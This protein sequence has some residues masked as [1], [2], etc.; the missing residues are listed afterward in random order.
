MG[1]CA[2]AA[3]VPA[4][5]IGLACFS[6]WRANDGLEESDGGAEVIAFL[7]DDLA[8]SSRDEL[9]TVL[10][11]L[12]GVAGVRLLGSDE[13]LVR[14][15]SALGDHAAVLDGVE[16]G[17]LPATL[18]VS[19]QPGH[20]GTARADDIADRLRRMDGITDV[21]VLRTA[22]S[23]RLARAGLVDRR[24][25]RVGIAVGSL[26]AILALGLAGAAMRRRRADAHL[27]A[28]LGFSIVAVGLPGAISGASYA[29]AGTLLGSVLACAAAYLGWSS[30]GSIV[31]PVFARWQSSSFPGVL[32]GVVGAFALAVLLGAALGWWGA[33]PSVQEIDD[34]ASSD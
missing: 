2:F 16:D 1:I 30:L 12:P 31:V 6:A 29:L 26:T 14:M 17:F 34:L 13:T 24:L 25:E 8:N 3:V 28:G 18:E 5:V 21:D 27:M 7:R 33:R 4:T 32:G 10:R 9:S 19:L 20:Q 22:L 15:R 23:Q 11:R